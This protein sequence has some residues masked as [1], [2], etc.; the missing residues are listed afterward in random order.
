MILRLI[1]DIQ[2]AAITSHSSSNH[3][4]EV[5]VGSREPALQSASHKAGSGHGGR[6]LRRT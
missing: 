2:N 6:S 4:D 3:D 5:A 1:G